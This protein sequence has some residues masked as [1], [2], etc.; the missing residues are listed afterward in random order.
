MFK[1]NEIN[2]E[3][4]L[5]S[6]KNTLPDN[7]KKRYDKS[8]GKS[9]FENVF[10]QIDESIFSVLFSENFSRPNNAVNIYASLEILKETFGI[11]DEELLD[12]FHFDNMFLFAMGLDEVGEKTISERA[13]YYMRKRVVE[14]EEQTGINLFDVLLKNI[15]S[16][17]LDKFKISKKQI[18]IDSTLIGSNIRK[19]N[20][21]KLFI[22]VLKVFLKSLDNKKLKK[23]VTEIKDFKNV[24]AENFVYTLSSD[25]SKD[26]EKEIA[27]HLY[28]MKWIFENDEDIKDT[29]KYKM[30]AQVVNEQLNISK[31]GK[32]VDLKDVS[33]LKGSSIQSPFDTD[34]TYKKKGTQARHGNSV[35]AVETCDKDNPF[36]LITNVITEKNIIDDSTILED[37]FEEIVDPETKDLMGDGAYQSEEIRKKAKKAE[38][39]LVTTAIKGRKIDKN[40]LSSTDFEIKSDEIIK[41]PRGEKPLNQSVDDDKII[42]YFSHA[43]CDGCKLNCLIKKNKRKEHRL[44]F[45]KSRIEL[46]KQ[47]L[48]FNDRDY[49]RKCRL[50]PAVEG[51]MFQFKLHLRNG[52]S[53]FRGTIKNRCRNTLRGIGINFK[54]VHAFAT[55]KMVKEDESSIFSLILRLFDGLFFKGQSVC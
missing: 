18:R 54:K 48:L 26:K 53:K 1:P 31:N 46:D 39:S 40:K 43:S 49:L 45:E 37:N 6:V 44:V 47:R 4:E 3:Q 30:L 9:F 20:R 42:A 2:L 27:E 21:I 17:Y 25:N 24:D 41:C 15:N 38:V 29:E 32:K 33:E 14:Y 28:K 8:W 13:F 7:L 10:T 34:A 22:E 16:H 23:V 52:K 19:L 35:T 51:T 12:R 50:R 5:F 36:Q 11:N 55:R